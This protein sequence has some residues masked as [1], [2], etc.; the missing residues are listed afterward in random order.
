MFFFKNALPEKWG[1]RD[2]R[3][4]YI[5]EIRSGRAEL[6]DL[7]VDPTE[8]RNLAPQHAELVE[9]YAAECEQWFIQS[10][11]EY[12]ARL[13]DFRPRGGRV[14]LPAE[15]RTPGPKVQSTGIYEGEKFTEAS[16]FAASVRPVVWNF[17][18]PGGQARPVRWRWISPSGAE[19][20]S[21][22]EVAGDWTSTRVPLAGPLPLE[23]GPWSVHVL[24][25][26]QPVLV[27]RFVIDR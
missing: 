19:S 27:S 2:G 3:W 6:Y 7:S 1:T 9:R 25:G 24:D 8:Q 26:V 14:V 12:T 21:V 11:A 4:K 17:W 10:E 18:V 13:R 20:W 22:M 5:G 15:Y 23:P 16:R